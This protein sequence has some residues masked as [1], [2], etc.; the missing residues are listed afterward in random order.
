MPIFLA[1]LLGG[2]V[3]IAGTL[4]GR[5]LVS[6]G[7]GYAS[8]TGID[9]SLDWMRDQV[10]S[11]FT[12]LPSQ[13]LAVASLLQIGPA[14]SILFSALAARLVLAGMTGGTI[15]KLVNRG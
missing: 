5:V 6:L 14:I 7:V 1:A 12:G 11:S 3:D 4:V 9:A 10:A 15:K 13:A 8:Y 2:L